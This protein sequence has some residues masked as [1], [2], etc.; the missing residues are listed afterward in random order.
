[1]DI[2]VDLDDFVSMLIEAEMDGAI[3][4]LDIDIWAERAKYCPCG[5]EEHVGTR[6]WCA[7][8]GDVVADDCFN[9]GEWYTQWDNECKLME[10]RD[11]RR[12][13]GDDY[14]YCRGCLGELI[15]QEEVTYRRETLA[16]VRERRF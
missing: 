3:S 15:I 5:L 11:L 6:A 9:C 14:G 16:R 10:I 8:C 1:M 13:L 12:E 4:A 7:Y 2:G